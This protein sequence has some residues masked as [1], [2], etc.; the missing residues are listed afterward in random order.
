M[1]NLLTIGILCALPLAA[2]AS[3]WDN[4]L[5]QFPALSG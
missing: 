2:A 5:D 1:R 3:G 4:S